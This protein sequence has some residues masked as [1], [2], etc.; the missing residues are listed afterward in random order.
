MAGTNRIA[1]LARRTTLPAL[2]NHLSVF[3]GPLQ[4]FAL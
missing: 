3:L 4:L 2:G 1:C